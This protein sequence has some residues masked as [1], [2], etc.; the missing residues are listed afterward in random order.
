MT[1]VASKIG[2]GAGV[3]VVGGATAAAVYLAIEYAR[4]GQIRHVLQR[5]PAMS[6][7]RYTVE[8]LAK[9]VR[10]RNE[11]RFVNGA[12]VPP[13][14]N[15]NTI[16]ARIPSTARRVPLLPP[17]KTPLVPDGFNRLTGAGRKKWVLAVRTVLRA[18]GFADLDARIIAQRWAVET[19]WDRACQQRNRGNI[20]AQGYGVYCESWQT[21]V[22]EQR[23]WL[24]NIPEAVG[25]HGL[26]D[27]ARSGDWYPSF[28]SDVEYARFFVRTI[29]RMGD[30]VAQA[31]RGG[32]EGARGFAAALTR[33]G[34]SPGSVEAH[35]SEMEG[36]WRNCQRM[37]GA[38]W[39]SLR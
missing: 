28:T 32:L 11:I 14:V 29:G 8:G 26:V 39:E 36:Y 1:S 35:V 17:T 27:R 9:L 34:Y 24:N 22:N 4:A 12:G 30:A 5:A 15:G 37:I 2:I 20:K 6:G 21:L 7:G 16:I 38:E 10:D 18:A 33:G 25:V 13:H 31:R 19:G 23:V 3:V